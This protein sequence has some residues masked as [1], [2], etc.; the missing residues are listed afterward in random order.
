MTGSERR[1]AAAEREQRSAA[2]MAQ[3]LEQA[4]LTAQ[5]KVGEGEQGWTF[6]A[7]TVVV[8]E[9]ADAFGRTSIKGEIPDFLYDDTSSVGDTFVLWRKQTEDF[10]GNRIHRPGLKWPWSRQYTSHKAGGQQWRE[11]A[12]RSPPG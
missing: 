2:G 7:D 10:L 3:Q 12:G 9:K 11:V 5:V 6:R 4:S 1:E 8:W